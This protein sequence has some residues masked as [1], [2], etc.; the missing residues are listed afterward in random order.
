[1]AVQLLQVKMVVL[2]VVPLGHKAVTLETALLVQQVPLDKVT[3]VAIQLLARVTHI[4]VPVVVALE[5]LVVTLPIETPL[6]PVEPASPVTLQVLQL[7]ALA[8]EAVE[9]MVSFLLTAHTALLQT[10][11]QVVVDEAVPTTLGSPLLL[12]KT[13]DQVVVALVLQA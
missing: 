8:A 7:L 1:M 13:L 6:E 12:H 5:P 9:L 10:V 3:T 11:D 2:V 4:M